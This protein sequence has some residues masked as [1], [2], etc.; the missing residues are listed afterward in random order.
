[1]FYYLVIKVDVSD[2]RRQSLLRRDYVAYSQKIKSVLESEFS[3]QI[4]LFD[5]TY[6]SNAQILVAMRP[7][8]T[9][10]PIPN[11]MVKTWTAEGTILETVWESRWP[12][13]IKKE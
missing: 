6:F 11:T 3:A 12:P 9:P 5:C 4:S 1:M 7:R 10:V 2:T 13:I 8:V